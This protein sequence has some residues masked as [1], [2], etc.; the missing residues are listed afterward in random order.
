MKTERQM[1]AEEFKALCT[2]KFGNGV[3]FDEQG[4]H[5]WSQLGV[6]DNGPTLTPVP[7]PRWINAAR[8]PRAQTLMGTYWYP[9]G[10]ATFFVEV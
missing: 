7:G 9:T 6:D 2:E 10:T 8:N 3:T 4:K 5:G 1:T